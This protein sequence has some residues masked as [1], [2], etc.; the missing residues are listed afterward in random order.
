[1]KKYKTP[2]GSIVDESVLRQKYGARFDS[3]VGNG[4]FTLH[5]ESVSS[6]VYKTP[7]G[8][9]VSESTLR[10]KYGDKFESLVSDGTLKKEAGDLD[11][12]A[13][14]GEAAVAPS[15]TPSPSKEKNNL[16]QPNIAIGAGSSFDESGSIDTVLGM[17]HLYMR[18][19]LKTKRLLKKQNQ[20][21][22]Q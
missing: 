5:T 21:R 4:T 13:S 12:L 20:F 17:F 7:N 9:S 8:S 15:P 16:A 18:L 10:E 6:D 19:Y 14:F 1:M 2:N 11:G 22:R 3:L